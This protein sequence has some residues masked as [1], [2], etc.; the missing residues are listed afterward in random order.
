MK[1]RFEQFREM[2]AKHPDAILLFRVG[3]CYELYGS[4]AVVAN[5]LFDLPIT[6]L[7]M[8]NNTPTQVSGFYQYSLDMYLPAL[9]RAGYRVAICEQ[10]VEPKKEVV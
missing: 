8:G 9:V 10:L 2:K 3:N 1:T 4:D 6:K 7:D 5:N